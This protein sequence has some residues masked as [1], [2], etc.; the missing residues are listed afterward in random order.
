MV[1]V[2]KTLIFIEKCL[3][4]HQ[5]FLILVSCWFLKFLWRLAGI[6][7]SITLLHNSVIRVSTSL[8]LI[9]RS[10][11]NIERQLTALFYCR[12]LFSDWVNR[13]AFIWKVWWFKFALYIV[14]YWQYLILNFVVYQNIRRYSRFLKFWLKLNLILS[15][16]D[17]LIGFFM[18]FLFIKT[19]CN[20]LLFI[21]N[22]EIR[23]VLWIDT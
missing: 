7:Q 9:L 19:L 15:K 14:I 8:L 13:F 16:Y 20:Y 5:C 6:S 23:L 12:V 1:L 22:S 3:S 18:I 10:I 17:K 11:T 21:L 4:I 2:N